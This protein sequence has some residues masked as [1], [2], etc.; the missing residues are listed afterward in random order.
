MDGRVVL[1]LGAVV[2]L[3]QKAGK[4]VKLGRVHRDREPDGGSGFREALPTVRGRGGRSW[5]SRK[6]CNVIATPMMLL[7]AVG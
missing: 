7:P 5:R 4:E 2:V 3:L 1:D 6:V